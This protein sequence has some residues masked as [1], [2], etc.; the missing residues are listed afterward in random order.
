MNENLKLK[1]R[2]LPKKPGC[3]LMKDK[4]DKII[5]IGKAKVLFNRVNSYFVGAHNYK[6]TKLVSNI[7]DFDYFVTTTEKESL[8]LEINLIKKHRPKYNIMLMDDKSYPYIKLTKYPYPSVRVVRESKKD[9]KS[10]YFGPYPNVYAARETIRLLNEV[11]PLRKCKKMPKKV[12]LYY[13][14]NQCLGPCVYDIDEVVVDDLYNSCFKFLKGDT[15]AL[16]N[17]IKIKMGDAII[18]LEFEKANE[19]KILLESIDNTVDKQGVQIEDNKDRDVFNFYVDRGYISLQALFIRN[20]KLLEKEL[21]LNPLYSNSIEEEFISFIMQYYSKHEFPDELIL[22]LEVDVS[23]IE[24]EI[25]CK[26]NQPFKGMRKNLL[27]LTLENAKNNLNQKFDIVSRKIDELDI[28]NDEL[29]KL[30]N[31]EITRVE[32]FDNSHISGNFT[33]GACVVYDYGV[34]NK[35][36]YRHYNL[37]ESANDLKSMNEVLYRRYFRILHDNLQMPDL[38]IVDGGKIQIDVA[39]KIKEQLELNLIICGLVKDE[40]HNTA[41]LMNEDYQILEILKDSPLFFLL[42]R[43]QDE[44]HNF[45]IGYHRLLRTKAQTKSILDQV[46]GIGEV[47]KKKLMDHFKSFKRLKQAT[48]EEITAVVP[49]KIAE[50]IYNILRK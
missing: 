15:K 30:L 19:Y 26:I 29:S 42:T 43:M 5:Y 4:N 31:T 28:A 41:N 21:L 11:Y 17:D 48:I 2:T 13:H 24:S 38:L 35:K 39:K 18:K 8:I 36:E 12:C 3:Y 32:L 49:K 14:L 46:D 23:L 45:A 7:V 22:P 33:V 40:R 10:K 1:L 47:R 9:K 25:K 6:T 44:V 37:E 27:D 34:P 50:E 20:G 16:E